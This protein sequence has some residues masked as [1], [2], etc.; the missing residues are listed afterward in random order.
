[1][2]PDS[3]VSGHIRHPFHLTSTH[4]LHLSS[5][6]MPQVNSFPFTCSMAGL[7]LFHVTM[8]HWNLK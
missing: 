3:H 6:H 7:S 1:M 4:S 8:L 2:T 5:T